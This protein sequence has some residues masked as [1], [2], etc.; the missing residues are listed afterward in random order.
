MKPA[1]F[2]LATVLPI[3]LVEPAISQHVG[4]SPDEMK[5]TTTKDLGDTVVLE[6]D[7]A[8]PAPYVLRIR[9][10]PN[11]ITNPHTHGQIENITVISGQIGFGLGTVFDKLKGRELPAGSF[12]YLPANTP[13]YAWTGPEGAVI[14]AHG[15]GPFP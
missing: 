8:R 13:H 7:P 4:V 10:P 11:H 2:V 9:V 14:Q 15:V 3:A 1:L 5:W 12:F 6:G